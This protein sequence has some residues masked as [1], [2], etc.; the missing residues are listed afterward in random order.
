MFYF[1]EH[2]RRVN[3]N[4]RKKAIRIITCSEY[5]AH[6]EPLFKL[7]ELLKVHYLYELKL[8]KFYYKLSYN[9]LPSYFN[10][11]LETINDILPDNY[12]PE[13]QHVPE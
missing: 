11:C 2:R 3:L 1:G 13:C 9:H 5:L 12:E 7:L 8:S 10:Y 6:T 4:Y